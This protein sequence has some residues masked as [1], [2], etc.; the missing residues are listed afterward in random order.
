[1]IREADKFAK[2]LLAVA[3]DA[4]DASDASPQVRGQIQAALSTPWVPKIDSTLMWRD[5]RSPHTS[6]KWLINSMA[7]FS[8]LAGI[9]CTLTVS[10]RLYF[11]VFAW[12]AVGC[13]FW[14]RRVPPNIRKRLIREWLPQTVHASCGLLLMVSQCEQF[15]TDASICHLLDS[16]TVKGLLFPLYG[17]S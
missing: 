13:G 5:S 17:S 4:A 3:P 2:K 8:S 11:A 15:W 9:S 6:A 7:W 12:S 1:M 10:S 14:L 16:W